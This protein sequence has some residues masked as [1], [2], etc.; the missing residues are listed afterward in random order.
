M[1]YSYLA[2]TYT[3]VQLNLFVSSFPLCLKQWYISQPAHLSSRPTG[4]PTTQRRPITAQT[5][6]PSLCGQLVKN[7]CVQAFFFFFLPFF[8]TTLHGATW[9]WSRWKD[10]SRGNASKRQ[11]EKELEEVMYRGGPA[12]ILDELN[13]IIC[14]QLWLNPRETK[15]SSTHQPSSDGQKPAKDLESKRNRKTQRRGGEFCRWELKQWGRRRCSEGPDSEDKS[16]TSNRCV[17]KDCS[18]QKETHQ[19]LPQRKGVASETGNV[20]RERRQK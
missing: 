16:E 15:Q 12:T 17:H 10:C 11:R 19:C 2:R 18:N 6:T 4:V 7:F 1:D 13:H 5:F 8:S 14:L 9:V 20:K 3:C